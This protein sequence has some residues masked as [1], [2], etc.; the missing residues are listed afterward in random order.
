M[1]AGLGVIIGDSPSMALIVREYGF[2]V[3]APSFEPQDAADVLNALTVEQIVTMRA[4]TRA[5]AAAI[6]ADTEMAKV[7]TMFDQLLGG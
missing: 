6:N 2:G 7:I 3:V 5:A 4:R 1:V